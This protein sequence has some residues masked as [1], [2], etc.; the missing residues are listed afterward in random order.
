MPVFRSESER[1]GSE[2]GSAG[3]HNRILLKQL[4]NQGRVEIG[5]NTNDH[6]IVEIDHPA[7]AII[8][9]HAVPGGRERMKFDYCL[10]VLDD[11]ML[12]LKLGA[13]RKNLAQ[14]RER[15]GYESPFC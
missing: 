11:Q 5:A 8:E 6:S 3:G 14:L 9:A 4:G 10:I 12:H 1:A 15:A 13:L 7:V 2:T